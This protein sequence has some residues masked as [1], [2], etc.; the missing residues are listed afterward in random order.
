MIDASRR[1]ESARQ[2][3]WRRAGGRPGSRGISSRPGR[4]SPLLSTTLL[5][6]ILLVIFVHSL[7]LLES[8][9]AAA[10]TRN[11]LLQMALLGVFWWWSTLRSGTLLNAPFVLVLAI[12]FWH[13]SFFAGR[14]LHVAEVFEYTGSVLTYGEEFIPRT[15]ALV[16]LC[17]AFAILGSVIAFYLRKGQRAPAHAR[18]WPP[19]SL[20]GTPDRR[21]G[22]VAALFAWSLFGAYLALTLVY[23]A[24]E[25]AGALSG[26]YLDLYTQASASVLYR[27]Y[28]MTKFLGV[29]FIALVIATSKT[30][31]AVRLAYAGTLVL[32]FVTALTGGRTMP[33]LYCVTLLVAVDYFRKPVPFTAIV[34]VAFAGAAASWIIT[35]GRAL[36]IG[37]HMFTAGL[38]A[39]PISL[40]H[41][42]WSTG[43]TVGIVLRTMEFTEKTGLLHG[44]SFAA[45]FIYVVPGPLVKWM[46]PGWTVEPPSEWLLKQSADSVAGE[47]MGYSLVAE[48][49]LN[50]GIAGCLVFLLIGWL[51]AYLYFGFR[52]RRDVFA[53]LQSLNLVI[54]LAL[55]LRNDS[56]TYVRV[57]V[58]G[59]VAIWIC[60]LLHSG[61]RGRA[62]V[63]RKPAL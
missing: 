35:Q 15:V 31:R 28:Q 36:G 51:V 4:I 39:P 45:A 53:A 8:T 21:A 6:L 55:H 11:L 46:A 30:E 14:Y 10:I 22:R 16:S 57:L 54:L 1:P 61:W 48:V 34:V 12:F 29:P 59:A 40:W 23:L 47:G 63:R 41:F 20:A 56:V 44:G 26:S 52:F 49:F 27:A 62:A 58:W 42:F 32:M 38:G 17:L 18:I 9:E 33:F 43:G 13:S 7:I 24:V 37:L 19:G 3:S 50:F 25:G 2:F 5:G 60:G